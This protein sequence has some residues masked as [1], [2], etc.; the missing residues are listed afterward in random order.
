MGPAVLGG[1]W[2]ALGLTGVYSEHRGCVMIREPPLLVSGLAS[3]YF[4]IH[5]LLSTP[6]FGLL[7]DGLCRWSCCGRHTSTLSCINAVPHDS[8]FFFLAMANQALTHPSAL[9]RSVVTTY[10]Q[11]RDH[12]EQRLGSYLDT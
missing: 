2:A 7:R 8:I 6:D 12:G 11:S 4:R 1:L 3:N 9:Y 5:A 10:N